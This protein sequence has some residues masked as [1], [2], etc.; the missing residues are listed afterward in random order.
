MN[1][2]LKR[3]GPAAR[4][5]ATTPPLSKAGNVWRTDAQ[6][7][8]LAGATVDAANYSI[9]ADQRY[10]PRL[11]DHHGGGKP[12]QHPGQERP[13]S[14]RARQEP[15]R[16]HEEGKGLDLLDVLNFRQTEEPP[17]AVASAATTA[18]PGCQPRSLKNMREKFG[19]TGGG[20]KKKA[21][22]IEL[23]EAWVGLKPSQQDRRRD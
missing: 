3:I 23:P 7:A 12:R 2:R 15:Q 16:Q 20:Q 4:I 22:E 14:Q 1:R 18:P 21:I 13:L 9:A 10:L 6:Q 17:S 19:K 8:R 5:D 11:Y